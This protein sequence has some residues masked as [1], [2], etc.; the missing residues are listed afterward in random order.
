MELLSR[1]SENTSGLLY[2]RTYGVE[3]SA[4]GFFERVR[5]LR[6]QTFIID[7]KCLCR[8]DFRSEASLGSDL[9]LFSTGYSKFA[10]IGG[11]GIGFLNRDPGAYRRVQLPFRPEH[12]ESLLE[13]MNDALKKDRKF[14]PNDSDWLGDSAFEGDFAK[15]RAQVEKASLIA[16]EHKDELNAIYSRNLPAHIQMKSEFQ[17]WRFNIL[18][19]DKQRLLENIFASGLFA[20]SHYAPLSK[21][22]SSGT[23]A[24]AREIHGRTVNLFNDFRF[25][26]DRALAACKIVRDHLESRDKHAGT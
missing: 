7:D 17:N 24:T 10:D 19:P 1:A 13:E 21:V 22:F 5:K 6:P 20:S 8:P 2:V 11:G 9:T 25:D 16:R 4:D 26:K 18:V 14:L 3:G 23:D 15:Y 12:H